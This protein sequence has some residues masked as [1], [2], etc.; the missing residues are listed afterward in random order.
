MGE[1][2]E[3]VGREGGLTAGRTTMSVRASLLAAVTIAVAMAGTAHAQ[4]VVREA[5]IKAE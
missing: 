4:T 2:R 5:G 3:G 1:S